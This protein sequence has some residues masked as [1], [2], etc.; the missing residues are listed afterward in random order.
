M[1]VFWNKSEISMSHYYR[2]WCKSLWWCGAVAWG[3]KPILVFSLAQA[4]QPY[5]FLDM[6][7]RLTIPD[8]QEIRGGRGDDIYISS[9]QE[10][11]RFNLK[12]KWLNT[13]QYLKLFQT[14]LYYFEKFHNR[15]RYVVMLKFNLPSLLHAITYTCIANPDLF[16]KP[17]WKVERN[18]SVANLS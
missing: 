16:T 3:S 5:L 1:E 18:L 7:L 13:T 14:I 11:S 9:Y 6:N 17:Y 4:E 8:A 12:S 10:L 2:K 15:V